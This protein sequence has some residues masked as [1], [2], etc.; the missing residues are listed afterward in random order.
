M[1]IARIL[2]GAGII[3]SYGS[4][5]AAA[6]TLIQDDLNVLVDTGHFGNR[7]VLLKRLSA[8]GIKPDEIDK[9]VL[10]H[11]NWDH[12]LNVDLFQNASIVL[13]KKEFV[14]GSLS[15]RG[16][17]ITTYYRNYLSSRHIVIAEDNTPVTRHSYILMT[18]GHTPGHISLIVDDGENNIIFSGDS[19]PNLRSYRRGLPDFIFYSKEEAI[20]SILRI[21]KLNPS[22]IIPGHDPPFNE[23]G[24][25]ENDIIDIILR[26]EDET[27]SIIKFN[28]DRAGGPVEFYE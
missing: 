1:K 21:K 20:S 25:L 4:M 27:N 7:D 22:M 5:G 3:S 9:I 8:E 26:N 19:I 23:G 16:D 14:N 6:V 12:C 13:S 2:K 28:K 15:G 18:P 10:T 17:F 24:Y 11:I